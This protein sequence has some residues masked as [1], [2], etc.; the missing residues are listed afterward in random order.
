M[1]IVKGWLKDGAAHEKVFDV[2]GDATV[3]VDVDTATCEPS[4]EGAASLCTV[5]TDPEFDAGQH[6]FYY[7]RVLETVS[8]RWSAR[9]CLKLS[10]AD[11]PAMCDDPAL[12]KVVQQ[13]AWSSPIWYTPT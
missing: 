8:C 12:A 2:A 4:S 9:E 13:R 10:G 6:A 11:R 7:A 3:G 1:Q 5:W